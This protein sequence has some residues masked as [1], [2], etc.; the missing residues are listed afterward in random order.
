MGIQQRWDLGKLTFGFTVFWTYLFWS[1]Y[2]PIWYGKIPHEQIWMVKRA[3]AP[4]GG[5]SVLTIVLCFV[6][7]FAG[8]LGKQ[9]K[10]RPGTLSLFTFV[11]LVGVW[12]E[13]Y[14]LV[15]P[16]IALPGAPV[17]NIWH[18]LIACFFAGLL[19]LS[20]RWFL[21]TFPVIQVWQPP[22]Q[23]EMMETERVVEADRLIESRAAHRS[24]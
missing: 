3:S 5:M 10:I 23:L 20:V 13:R 14:M 12:L 8:L 17:F 19:I 9:P 22:V 16:S 18:P 2:L 24:H 21:A 15:A 6:V 1:Q 4:W 11:I 7:P